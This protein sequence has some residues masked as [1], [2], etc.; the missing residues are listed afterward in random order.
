MLSFLNMRC[1]NCAEPDVMT[2]FEVDDV[3]TA[4]AETLLYS[5]D[6]PPP[7]KEKEIKHDALYEP[8]QPMK[9]A[10]PVN[11]KG[12]GDRVRGQPNAAAPSR[13]TDGYDLEELLA[14]RAPMKVATPVRVD[15]QS[16][17][18]KLHEEMQGEYSRRVEEML[19]PADDSLPHIQENR[20]RALLEQESRGAGTDLDLDAMQASLAPGSDAARSANFDAWAE[21]YNYPRGNAVGALDRHEAADNDDWARREMHDRVQEEINRTKALLGMLPDDPSAPTRIDIATMGP[22][23]TDIQAHMERID[24]EITGSGAASP[25]PGAAQKAN[26]ERK[27]RLKE[28]VAALKQQVMKAKALRVERTTSQSSQDSF[29]MRDDVDEL[30]NKK[31]ELWGA[32]RRRDVE[33]EPLDPDFG[34]NRNGQCLSGRGD[35]MCFGGN[36]R[37]CA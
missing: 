26:D 33:E 14:A 24:E 8:I 31:P 1:G 25:L 10:T 35:R 13:D 36:S 34:K 6:F 15:R 18:L 17:G 21:K 19:R 2:V 7:V 9:I 23:L 12:Q 32:R 16:E 5:P 4:K 30:G 11:V 3:T 28:E 27:L 37:Q 29:E 20:H 22:E